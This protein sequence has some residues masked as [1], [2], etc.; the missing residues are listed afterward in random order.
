MIRIISNKPCHMCSCK[1][2]IE[3]KY[4]YSSLFTCSSCDFIWTED[5][6]GEITHNH[7]IV[8]DDFYGST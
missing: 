4:E 1:E 7:P 6:T 5:D 3:D 8:R 2:V